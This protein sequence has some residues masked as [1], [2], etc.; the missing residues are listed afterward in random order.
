MKKK[1]IGISI[2]IALVMLGIIYSQIDWVYRTNKANVGKLSND[3]DAAMIKALKRYSEEVNSNIDSQLLAVLTSSYDTVT[4]E[5]NSSVDSVKIILKDRESLK[6]T[7]STKSFPVGL[8]TV[9]FPNREQL[10]ADTKTVGFLYNLF[11]NPDRLC[12]P[13]YFQA[14]SAKIT[15]Y[16]KEELTKSG[17]DM[18][19]PHLQMIYVCSEGFLPEKFKKGGTAH[20]TA[21]GTA[22]HEYKSSNLAA[23]IAPDRRVVM[24]YFHSDSEYTWPRLRAHIAVSALLITISIA[25]F[26]YLFFIII[27]QK[28][29]AEMKDDF[30]NNMTHELKTPIAIISAAVEGMQNFNALDD[31]E[32]TKR[33]LE[34]SRK[35]L[36]RLN[37]LV[38][39]VLHVASYQ[40]NDIQLFKERIDIDELMKEVITSFESHTDKALNIRFENTS[41]LNYLEADPIHFRNAVSNLVD[42]AIKYSGE[43]ADLIINCFTKDKCLNISIADKGI[44]IPSSQLNQI[45]EKFHRV[46]TG[47]L[48]NVKGTG[49]GLSYVKYVIEMH[50]GIVA[51]KSELNKGSEFII[52]IPY[53][54]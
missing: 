41:N 13:Y 31:K 12:K 54:A 39:K 37:D 30:I 44:G 45:F 3:A 43:Q 25:S 11:P 4:I 15:Q 6:S 19:L 16:F 38:T 40:K 33:Y 22:Y 47:N 35:E 5:R 49:L 36:N 10:P 42:N 34:T 21:A 53:R 29:L 17:M 8:I 7:Q 48:H 14:D 1:L 52:S 9:M 20:P 32:K 23:Y 24:A 2:V 28:R 51:V 46:S 26:I 18:L 50:G 27:R